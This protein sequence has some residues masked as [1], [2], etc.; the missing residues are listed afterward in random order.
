MTTSALV[1]DD[2]RLLLRLIE[3]NLTKTGMRV[4]LADSGE[5]AIRIALKEMPNIILLDL[6]MPMMDG[7]EVMRRLKTTAE[8]MDIPIVMLTAK[9]SQADRRRCEELGA[10]AF[11]GK[12]FNLEELR[13]TVSSLLETGNESPA[14]SG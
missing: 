12:P 14:S 10:V 8:T 6:M 4:L 3:L 9:S 1:V 11:I 7:Y 13:A 2:D 5:Q